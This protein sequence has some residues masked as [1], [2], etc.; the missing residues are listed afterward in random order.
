[1]QGRGVPE[2]RGVAPTLPLSAGTWRETLADAVDVVA[3]DFGQFAHTACELPIDFDLEPLLLQFAISTG[4]I[5]HDH[6]ALLSLHRLLLKSLGQAHVVPVETW[7]HL[8]AFGVTKQILLG[9]KAT[10]IERGR[11]DFGA[12][13]SMRPHELV[14][15]TN[16]GQFSVSTLVRE[17]PLVSQFPG[18]Q[19]S[20]Y[21]NFF[22]AARAR[23]ERSRKIGI[24]KAKTGEHSS[25][26]PNETSYVTIAIVA[27]DGMFVR[28][29][30]FTVKRYGRNVPSS[31]RPFSLASI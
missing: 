15:R 20:D 25:W 17:A 26:Y 31:L 21:L 19:I 12:E 22:E 6:V 3:A 5:R 29:G 1:M 7:D 16:S 27:H 2:P 8:R 18:P 14:E 30:H 9:R 13:Y 10:W 28:L 23:G 11:A 4:V 24:S